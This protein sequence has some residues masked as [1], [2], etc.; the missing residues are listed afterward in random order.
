[1]LVLPQPSISVIGSQG[2]VWFWDSFRK[3]LL[4]LHTFSKMGMTLK[5]PTWPL[6][7][8]SSPL[9]GFRCPHLVSFQASL[10]GNPIG[11]SD[12]QR[13]WVLTST[14]LS[15]QCPLSDPDEQVSPRVVHSYIVLP[16]YSYSA[17]LGTFLSL[18]IFSLSSPGLIVD[19]VCESKTSASITHPL[20]PQTC[21]GTEQYPGTITKVMSVAEVQKYSV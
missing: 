10:P 17:S 11:K 1:M 16:F 4:K 21:T 8:V 3:S 18:I 12:L 20:Q 19:S 15:I 9:P 5:L 6:F 14:I 13:T 2:P 7:Q